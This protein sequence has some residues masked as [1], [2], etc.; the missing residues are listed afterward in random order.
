MATSIE[1]E[2]PVKIEAEAD[3]WNPP[4]VTRHIHGQPRTFGPPPTDLFESYQTAFYS[5]QRPPPQRRVPVAV[6]PTITPQTVAFEASPEKAEEKETTETPA[7]EE[8]NFFN[9]FGLL[10]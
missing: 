3:D 2:S 9:L 1:T 4:V 10:S 7:A 5:P 8:K 6:V